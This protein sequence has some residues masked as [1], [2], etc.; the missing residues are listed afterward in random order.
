MKLTLGLR[1]VYFLVGKERSPGSAMWKNHDNTRQCFFIKLIKISNNIEI[2]S[3][4][5]LKI[6]NSRIYTRNFPNV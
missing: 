3:K 6:K 2:N 4:L 1:Y 5:I